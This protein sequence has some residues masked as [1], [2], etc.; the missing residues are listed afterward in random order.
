[1]AVEGVSVIGAV[2]RPLAPLPDLEARTSAL[3]H[4]WHRLRRTPCLRPGG[5]VALRGRC[6]GREQSEAERKR[7]A[8]EQKDYTHTS[9]YES[10]YLTRQ[11]RKPLSS[12]PTFPSAVRSNAAHCG[13]PDAARELPNLPL[14]DA[15]LLVRLYAEK[16]S[17]KYEKAAMRLLARYL[18][19][20]S[21]RLQHFAEITADLASR[22]E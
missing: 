18:A 13:W 9:D 21:P 14:E 17:P 4:G 10:L 11:R 22:Q 6:W 20:A 5:H 19:E 8:R 7:K 16:E 15:L 2:P 12:K 3:D 1:V